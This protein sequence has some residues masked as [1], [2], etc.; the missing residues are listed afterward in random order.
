MLRV[1]KKAVNQIQKCNYSARALPKAHQPPEVLY[2]G[3][4]ISSIFLLIEKAIHTLLTQASSI[5]MIP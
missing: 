5:I 2:S 1:F 3:V 4:S